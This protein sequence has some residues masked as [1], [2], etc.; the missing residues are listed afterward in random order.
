VPVSADSNYQMTFTASGLSTQRV[1]AVVLGRNV[2]IDYVPAYQPPVISGPN[3]AMLNQNNAYTFSPVGG[4]TSHQWEQT[5]M[6]PFTTVEG[7]EGGTGDVTLQVTAGYSVYSTDTAASGS[8][9]FHLAHPGSQAF[10]P[11]DQFITLN[12]V[13]LARA[14][15]QLTFMKKLGWATSSQVL[16]AQISTNGGSSWQN[17]W[18]QTGTG[19]SGDNMFTQVSVSL[20]GYAGQNIQLRFMYDVMGGYYPQTDPGVGAYIDNITVLNVDQ[21]SSPVASVIISGTNFVFNPTQ[22]GNY[23]LRVRGQNNGNNWP[24]GPSLSVST[25]TAPPTLQALT[26]VVT[27]NQVQIEFTVANPA[28]NMTFQLWKAT[29]ASGIYALDNGATFQTITPNTRFRATTTTGG[30]PTSFYKVRVSY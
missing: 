6:V 14:N 18:S 12:A 26:P 16:R 13:L 21:A 27:G 22:S 5:R 20:A 3:P 7:A 2:K 4:A 15:S 1:A 23:V 11:T 10:P 30:A 17:L 9:S 19:G 29:N 8:Y 24:W 25:I 28:A